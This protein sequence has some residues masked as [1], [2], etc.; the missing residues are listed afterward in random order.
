LESGRDGAFIDRDLCPP[1]PIVLPGCS[2]VLPKRKENEKKEEK[3]GKRRA[4][5]RVPS[6]SAFNPISTSFRGNVLWPPTG[7]GVGKRGEEEGKKE[8]GR[9]KRAI[10][11]GNQPF[12]WRP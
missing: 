10:T 4:Y 11:F 12:P 1:L 2:F 9:K 5:W 7:K 6:L 8:K 3:W